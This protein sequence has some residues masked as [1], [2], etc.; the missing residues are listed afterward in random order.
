M[1]TADATFRTLG[2][3]Q[4]AAAYGE[5]LRAT[6]EVESRVALKRLSNEIRSCR[7]LGCAE[8]WKVTLDPLHPDHRVLTLIIPTKAFADRLEET[9]HGAD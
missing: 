4:E 6:R 2:Q 5:A 3:E 9:L 1:T 7:A 8:A